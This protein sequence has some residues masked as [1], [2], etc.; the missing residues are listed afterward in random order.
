MSE[1][2]NVNNHPEGEGMNHTPDKTDGS[3]GVS[4]S[5]QAAAPNGGESVKTVRFGPIDGTSVPAGQGSMDLLLDIDLELSVELGTTSIQVRDVLNMG[6]GS[7]VELDKLAG[8]PVDILING[9]SIAKGEVVVV[10]DHFGVRV[11][12]ISSRSERMNRLA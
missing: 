6:P 11:T 8:E 9:K 5:Q 7:I 12:E 2:I 10:D 4:Q 3:A 1:E